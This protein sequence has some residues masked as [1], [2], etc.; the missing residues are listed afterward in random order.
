M[1]KRDEGKKYKEELL[2]LIPEDKRTL[3]A[4]AL[5]EAVEDHLGEHVLMRSDYSK[6]LDEVR[7][8]AE[9][10]NAYNGSLTDWYTQNQAALTEAARLKEENEVLRTQ[11]AGNGNPPEDPDPES[12][13]SLKK[14]TENFIPRAEAQKLLDAR[15]AQQANEMVG[16]STAIADI[17]M[18]HYANF[19]EQLDTNQVMQHALKSKKDLAGAYGELFKDRYAEKTEKE[20]AEKDKKREQELRQKIEA[21]IREK[22]PGLPYQ[23]SMDAGLS[24]ILEAM[25]KKNEKSDT[26]IGAAVDEFYRMQRPQ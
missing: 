26:G 12:T 15:L 24:P 6:K 18:Q 3:V 7:T 11:R 19:G 21:E 9:K 4:E 13:A 1:A 20:L 10:V 16:F 2:K 8:A 25:G 22:N 5:G 14:I 17:K 23:V